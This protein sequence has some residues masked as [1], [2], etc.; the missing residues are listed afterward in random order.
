MEIVPLTGDLV[1]E[2][3]VRSRDIDHVRVGQRADVRLTAL[4]QRMTPM[5]HGHVVYVS[6]DALPDDAQARPDPGQ[7]YREGHAGPE[8]RQPSIR[9]SSPSPECRQKSTSRPASERFF[10]YLI[11][12][13]TDSMSRAFREH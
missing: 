11:K 9:I 1:V 12:P 6:A 10:E 8:W 3:R 7:L 13:V 2:A 4:N 5:A